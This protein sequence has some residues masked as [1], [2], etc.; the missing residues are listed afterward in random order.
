MGLFS[1]NSDTDGIR[2]AEQNAADISR[3]NAAKA[4]DTGKPVYGIDADGW[5]DRA[6]IFQA[7]ADRYS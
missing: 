2:A 6:A 7:E 3:R 1:R 5:D 4:A